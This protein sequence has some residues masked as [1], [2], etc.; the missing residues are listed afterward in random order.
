MCIRD[1]PRPHAEKNWN[2]GLSLLTPQGRVEDN[3]PED[4]A[5]VF[6]TNAGTVVLTGC[7]HAGIVNIAEYAGQLVGPQ[8]LLAVIGGLHLF[9]AS[10]ETLA[11]TGERLKALGLKS[12]LA[13]HC[14]GLE[15]TYLLR[16]ATGLQR[17]TALVSTVGATFTLGQGLTSGVLAR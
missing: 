17:K 16:A 7:G 11:W 15:A 10:D 1:S 13:G 4:S 9:D 2:P 6:N 12:L 3:V 5:L 8:P 14:T